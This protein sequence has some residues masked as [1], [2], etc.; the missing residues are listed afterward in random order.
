MKRGK[1]LRRYHHDASLARQLCEEHEEI[2]KW[3]D[4]V[5]EEAREGDWY[6]CYEAWHPF[7]SLIERHMQFEERRLFPA[8][9]RSMPGGAQLVNELTREHQQIRDQ[10][11]KLSLDIELHMASADRIAEMVALL[12]QHA[13]H[14]DESLHPWVQASADKIS[15]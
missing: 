13:A 12:R 4:F 8:V 10:M 9:E 5:V 11:F 1:R 7:A 2:E 15:W 3:F 14:E 6:S